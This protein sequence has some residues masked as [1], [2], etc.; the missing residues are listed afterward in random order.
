MNNKIIFVKLVNPRLDED[1]GRPIYKELMECPCLDDDEFNL[2]A[3]IEKLEEKLNNPETSDEEWFWIKDRIESFGWHID[4]F[5]NRYGDSEDS[6]EE[7]FIA[8]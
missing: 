1:G 7:Y 6:E 5:D 2:N 4:W 3:Y 8:M